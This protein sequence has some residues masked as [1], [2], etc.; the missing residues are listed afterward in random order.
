MRFYCPAVGR[1][2]D[3]FVVSDQLGGAVEYATLCWMSAGRSG[4]SLYRS[5]P[6][7]AG[8]IIFHQAEGQRT[9]HS[10]ALLENP[11]PHFTASAQRD[12]E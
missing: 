8:E 6:L 2:R 12:F 7:P 1:G 3:C 10:R 5:G 9:C 4:R 11:Q